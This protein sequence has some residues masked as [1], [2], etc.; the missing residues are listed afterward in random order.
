MNPKIPKRPEG[1]SFPEFIFGDQLF[2]A[3]FST[4]IEVIA[5]VVLAHPLSV[6]TDRLAQT[7]DQPP[8]AIRELLQGLHRAGLIEQDERA[9]SGKAEK[10]A[11]KHTKSD[12]AWCCGTALGNITLADVYRSV[13]EAPL[14]TCAKRRDG[15][16]GVGD[17]A[18]GANHGAEAGADQRSG[19]RQSVELL[20]MQATM[21]INQAVLQHL[22]AFD[23][24]RLRALGRAQ[25]SD[26]IYARSR[27]RHTEPV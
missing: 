23:L 25:C 22:Q 18:T 1:S 12:D 11:E 26:S 24:E 17:P 27:F 4:A 5:R 3:R 13:T 9:K 8:R 21:G 7:L 19:P 6:T 20:L 10:R 15:Y 14:A 16:G 2:H